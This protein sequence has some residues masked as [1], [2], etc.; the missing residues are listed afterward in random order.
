MSVGRRHGYSMQSLT[1]V[2]NIRVKHRQ[3]D[4]LLRNLRP[5][6][7]DE[8]DEVASTEGSPKP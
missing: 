5:S 7:D 3:P 4:K 2:S 8:A 1:E 6:G